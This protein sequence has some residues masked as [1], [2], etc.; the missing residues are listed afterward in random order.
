LAGLRPRLVGVVTPGHVQMGP[1]HLAA[2]DRRV[3]CGTDIALAAARTPFP[4]AS[5][6]GP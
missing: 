5:R 2:Q 3:D 6:R 1:L 4:G